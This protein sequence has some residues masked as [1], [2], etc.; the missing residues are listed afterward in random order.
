MYICLYYFFQTKLI[1]NNFAKFKKRHKFDFS[2]KKKTRKITDYFHG[3]FFK[4]QLFTFFW[5]F[6]KIKKNYVDALSMKLSAMSIFESRFRS[7]N[8]STIM[9]VEIIKTGSTPGDMVSAHCSAPA[10]WILFLSNSAAPRS[11][12]ARSASW[13]MRLLDNFLGRLTWYK[14]SQFSSFLFF[15]VLCRLQGLSKT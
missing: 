3:R 14:G 11:S 7:R 12:W 4:I 10:N 6:Y 5:N 9:T 15:P 1:F 13:T 2:K 8:S